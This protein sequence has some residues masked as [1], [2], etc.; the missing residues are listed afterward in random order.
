MNDN[1]YSESI[2]KDENVWAGWALF[3]KIVLLLIVGYWA[4]IMLRTRSDMPWI[5]LSNVDLL[6]HE[7]GHL[8]FSAFGQFVM[9]LGGTLAQLLIPLTVIVAFGWKKEWFSAYFGV[10]WLG[11]SAINASYYI[12]DARAQMLPLIGGDSSIHDWNWLLSRMGILEKDGSIGQWVFIIG[13]VLIMI[14]LVGM[15]VEIGWSGYKIIKD[16]HQELDSLK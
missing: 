14:A 4:N 8:I 2:K 11:E 10:F 7:G 15:V 13:A 12:K 9:F 3:G 6:F 16:R 5:F 1:N